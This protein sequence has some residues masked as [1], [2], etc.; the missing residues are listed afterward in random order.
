MRMCCDIQNTQ[1]FGY[2]I[3]IIPSAW[4][5]CSLPAH[6]ISLCRDLPNA[7]K[8]KHSL[9]CRKSK[10][11]PP[12]GLRLASLTLE[13]SLSSRR[14]TPTD[15]V[16]PHILLRFILTS[17]ACSR[18][19]FFCSSTVV[20]VNIHMAYYLTSFYGG[21]LGIADAEPHHKTK[22]NPVSCFLTQLLRYDSFTTPQ[23]E[24]RCRY[25]KRYT[26]ART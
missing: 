16:M 8:A 12:L 14:P 7:N 22:M 20:A 2:R 13:P 10:K 9:S 1:R 26:P 6:D 23:M 3:Y 5:T 19:P 17:T 21:S 4:Y 18:Q 15:P 24:P 11:P 25:C